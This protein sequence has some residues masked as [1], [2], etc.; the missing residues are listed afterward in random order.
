MG[1]ARCCLRIRAK[2]A[3]HLLQLVLQGRNGRRALRVSRR[4][5]AGRPPQ[6]DGGVGKQCPNR[7]AHAF[8]TST[9]SWRASSGAEVYLT[10]SADHNVLAGA[11]TLF[12]TFE[13]EALRAGW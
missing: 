9:R 1:T 3:L 12:L 11:G 7:R 6:R 10:A 2:Q 4:R 13:V 8:G 5:P